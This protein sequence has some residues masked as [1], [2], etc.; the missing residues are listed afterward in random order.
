MS[1]WSEAPDGRMRA[2]AAVSLEEQEALRLAGF[3]AEA[4]AVDEAQTL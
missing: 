2:D 3:L 1:V 4:S